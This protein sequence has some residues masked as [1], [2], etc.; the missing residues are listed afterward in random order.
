MCANIVDLAPAG[1]AR[2]C[3]PVAGLLAGHLADPAPAGVACSRRPAVAGA[4]SLS[5]GHLADPAPVGVTRGRGSAAVGA[6]GMSTE[7]GL[8]R[9]TCGCN[10]IVGLSAGHGPL[11]AACGCGPAAAVG[12]RWTCGPDSSAGD[13]RQEEVV[14]SRLGNLHLRL[15]PTE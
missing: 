11:R 3:D 14:K 12:L 6:A 1:V 13:Q 5:A 8:L 9:A 15:S 4:T 2:G 10:P 7:H